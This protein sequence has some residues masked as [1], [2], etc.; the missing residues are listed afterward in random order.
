MFGEV[1]GNGG[2]GVSG[3]HTGGKEGSSSKAKIQ[4]SYFKIPS[5]NQSITYAC[6]LTCCLCKY[7]SQF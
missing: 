7:F 3:R 5:F 2:P 1:V 6:R 4:N